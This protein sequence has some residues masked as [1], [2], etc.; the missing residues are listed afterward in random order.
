M[1]VLV[2]L[3]LTAYAQSAQ[4][5]KQ[6]TTK[7][8]TASVRAVPAAPAPSSGPSWSGFYVGGLVGG[9]SGKSD[10]A[11]TTVFSSTGYFATSSVPAIITAGAGTIKTN[12]LTFGGTAG[13][14]FQ[15]GHVVFGA[16]GDYS[17]LQLSGTLSSGD[18]VYPCCAPTSFNVTQSIDTTWLATVR[19]RAGVTAGHALFY[20]TYGMA[21]T[22]LN[23]QAVFTDTFATAHE[24]GGRDGTLSTVVWGGG[25]EIW[26]NNHFSVKG[27]YLNAEFDPAST[28]STNLTAFT[29]SIA[30]PTNV[31]THSST[32]KLQVYRGGITI[33]F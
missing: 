24:N 19:G 4:P 1:L 32:L 6:D 9:A 30:F 8:P 26:C 14:N 13:Y 29:P 3:P 22:D 18:V 2:S 17:S 16:E 31:F 15:V 28:T 11:T 12:E 33:R 25:V 27:E 7:T 10:V 20:G 5:A 23:Y 21:W